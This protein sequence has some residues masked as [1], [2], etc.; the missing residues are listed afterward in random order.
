ML[1][2]SCSKS[3]FTVPIAAEVRDYFESLIKSLVTKESL[4]KFSEA[5]QEKIGKRFEEKLDEQNPNIIQLQ[6]KF[7]IRDN[8]LQKLEIICDNNEQY[9][10]RS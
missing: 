2:T 5:L 10:C 6:S 8:A 7:P 1:T 9:S 4:E 3:K